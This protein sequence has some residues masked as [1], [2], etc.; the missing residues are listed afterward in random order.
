MHRVELK[1]YSHILGGKLANCN[2][3]NAPCGVESLLAVL[4]AYSKIFVPNAPCGVER[5]GGLFLLSW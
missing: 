3:P 2:V 5:R 4:Q 1:G